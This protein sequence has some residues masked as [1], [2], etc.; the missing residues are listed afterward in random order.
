MWCSR[1]AWPSSFALALLVLGCDSPRPQAR[2]APDAGVMPALTRA[3]LL[4]P[5]SCKS[6][7]PKHY[8]EWRSSMHAYAADD[9]VFLAMN[10]RGQRETEGALGDF[11]VG[12]HAPMAVREGETSD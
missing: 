4:D 5:A 6:C 7:H 8:R 10:K 12:C 9:P 2:P 1:S 3:Q 11:C